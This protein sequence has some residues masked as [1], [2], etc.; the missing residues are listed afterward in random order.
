V[1][2]DLEEMRTAI[3]LWQG[4]VL[5]RGNDGAV[6]AEQVP[7]KLIRLVDRA[8]ARSLQTLSSC[9]ASAIDQRALRAMV[10]QA[11]GFAEWADQASL[12]LRIIAAL[13]GKAQRR[14][15]AP[16]AVQRGDEDRALRP[17]M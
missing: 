13:H 10:R 3:D 7:A 15:R 2:S 5:M 8:A 11:T 16:A 17:V 6:F 4:A 1:A 9:A 14:E 12:A